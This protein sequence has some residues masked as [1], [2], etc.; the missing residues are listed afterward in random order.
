MSGLV[1][2]SALVFTLYTFLK[3][4]TWIKWLQ[5][6]SGVALIASLI[7]IFTHLLCYEMYSVFVVNLLLILIVFLSLIPSLNKLITWGCFMVVLVTFLYS[8][9]GT[10]YVQIYRECSWDGFTLKNRDLLK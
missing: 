4:R 6:A 7:P 8:I 3:P 2:I 1:V 9:I 5:V 10:S